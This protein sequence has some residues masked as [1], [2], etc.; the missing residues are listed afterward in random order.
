MNWRDKPATEKQ[1]KLINEMNEFSEFELP[2]FTGTTRGEAS[3]YIDRWLA[4][5]HETILSYYDTTQGRA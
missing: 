1:I 5:S 3:D 4:T 2:K